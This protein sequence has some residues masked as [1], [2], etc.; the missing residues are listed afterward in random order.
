MVL[1]AEVA[2]REFCYVTTTGRTSGGAHRI[3]IWFAAHPERDTIY[4][5]SGAGDQADWVRNLV[6]SPRCNVELGDAVYVG[7]ARLIV[8]TDEDE[9]ARTLVHDKY[10]HGD[11]LTSWRATALPIA[12]DLMAVT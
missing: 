6:S 7:D 4:L 1:A 9:P 10:A 11:D 3:E 5:L 12:I 2:E 8:G